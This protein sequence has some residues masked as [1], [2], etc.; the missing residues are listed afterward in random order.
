MKLIYVFLMLLTL[1]VILTLG[2]IMDINIFDP[3]GF[4]RRVKNG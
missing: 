1:A 3:I 4:Y 2:F